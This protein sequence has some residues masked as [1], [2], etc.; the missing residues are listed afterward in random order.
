MFRNFVS[1]Q[2]HAPWGERKFPG[3]NHSFYF[4]YSKLMAFTQGPIWSNVP[5]RDHRR[6]MTFSDNVWIH[7]RR[8]EVGEF[9]V[10]F[11]SAFR[12]GINVTANESK[13]YHW[14]TSDKVGQ[15]LEGY[16]GNQIEESH[17]TNQSSVTQHCVVSRS[18]CVLMSLQANKRSGVLNLI[19]VAVLNFQT[20]GMGHYIGNWL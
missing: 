7:C 18:L 5:R 11:F 20:P 10:S 4:S 8:H 14:P 17:A 1:C 13:G 19:L 6:S 9:W 2:F 16:L 12:W 3:P 15:L